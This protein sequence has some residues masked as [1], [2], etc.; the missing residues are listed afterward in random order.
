MQCTLC[1]RDVGAE[2]IPFKNAIVCVLCIQELH[3]IRMKMIIA[4]TKT[5]HPSFHHHKKINH[6]EI[7]P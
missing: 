3:E 7:Y 1:K 2:Y 6:P 5:H 4:T